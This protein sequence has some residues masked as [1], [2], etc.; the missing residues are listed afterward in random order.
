ML[1]RESLRV[2]AGQEKQPMRKWSI[3]LGIPEQNPGN[4][5]DMIGA[6]R[7][8][9]QEQLSLTLGSFFNVPPWRPCVDFDMVLIEQWQSCSR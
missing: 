6:S 2:I 1:Y 4:R 9:L 8:Y 3:Q 7:R 5:V